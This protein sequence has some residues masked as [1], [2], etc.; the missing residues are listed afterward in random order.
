MAFLYLYASALRKDWF[1]KKQTRAAQMAAMMEKRLESLGQLP[2]PKP[3]RLVQELETPEQLA[4]REG[5]KKKLRA[6]AE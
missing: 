3:E 2:E 4:R 5:L 1:M 6:F